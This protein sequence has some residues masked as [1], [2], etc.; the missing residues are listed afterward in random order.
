MR[1]H[2]KRWNSSSLP[3]EPSRG[4]ARWS[5]ENHPKCRRVQRDIPGPHSESGTAGRSPPLSP[6]GT[7]ADT[8]AWAKGICLFMTSVVLAKCPATPS[9]QRSA[10]TSVP[11]HQRQ[12]LPRRPCRGAPQMVRYESSPLQRLYASRPARLWRAPV[13]QYRSRRG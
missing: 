8:T 13:R 5:L 3:I 4:R 1:V 12:E 9:V 7:R 6:T 10:S 11:R 2:R